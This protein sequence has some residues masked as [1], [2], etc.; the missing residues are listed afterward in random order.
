MGAHNHIAAALVGLA[1]DEREGL[2]ER[3]VKA[4]AA[5]THALLAIAEQ[6]RVANLLALATARHGGEQR[7]YDAVGGLEADA[8][9]TEAQQRLTGGEAT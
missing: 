9:F 5:Q 6:L 8:L 7:G 2:T 1:A 3:R 4:A